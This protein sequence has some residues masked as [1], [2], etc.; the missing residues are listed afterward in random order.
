MQLQV[1]ELKEELRQ[2][3]DEMKLLMTQIEEAQKDVDEAKE[4]L[5]QITQE[6]PTGEE[7]RRCAWPQPQNHTRQSKGDGGCVP[8][9]VDGPKSQFPHACSGL[10]QL[11]GRRRCPDLS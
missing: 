7:F 3:Y 2:R 1:D 11:L 8:Q 5:A 10:D 6:R 4:S 9:G